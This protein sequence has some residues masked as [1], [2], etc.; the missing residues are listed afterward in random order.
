MSI[1]QAPLPPVAH[2]S[3]PTAAVA[4]VSAGDCV[5]SGQPVAR[6]SDG[7]ALHAT[8]S[9]TIAAVSTSAGGQV[10]V[11][12]DSDGRDEW[13]DSCVPCKAPLALPP[14]ELRRRLLDGGIV[15]LGGALFPSG[16]KLDSAPRVRALIINGAECEP[17]ITCDEILLR[18]R[19][20]QVVE[21]ARI[22]MHA[23]GTV[24]AVI[25]VE[26]DMPEARI[27]LHDALATSGDDR[28][29]LAVVSAKYPAGGERQLIEMLTGAEVPLGGLPGDVGYLCQNAGTAAAAAD[30][31]LL[32][33]PLV[34]RIVTVTGGGVAEPG[35]FEVR[36]GTPLAML[37][38][39]AG[40]YKGVPAR[41]I[42]GGPM[43]GVAQPDD[44]A[45]V[46]A[47]TNCVVAALADDIAPAAPEMPC[48]RCGDCVQACPAR[49]LPHEL[50]AASRQG[51][52]DALRDLHLDACI[53]CGCCDYVCPSMIPLTA[54][55]AAAKAARR[56]RP[57]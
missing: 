28:I 48:I 43:M 37:V 16:L 1:R 4:L 9:G 49:L 33:R 32:G 26:T 19:A 53:E 42:V 44:A 11:A 30:L 57:S 10:D 2:L 34:S 6:G 39:A 50:L 54:A 21:G 46:T 29:G 25:A 31:L 40:G 56:S 27:A 41:L 38:A 55:F 24:H 36:L 3:T 7:C 45:A 18:E 17:W 47:A 22:L 8:I 14:R 35:N 13:H 12:I 20:T 5:K 23:A 52:A 51:H 15:G